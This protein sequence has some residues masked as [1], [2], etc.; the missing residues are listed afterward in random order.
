M[1]SVHDRKSFSYI[2]GVQRFYFTFGDSKNYPFVG[3]WVEVLAKNLSQAIKAFKAV[4]PN[5][6][7]DEVLCCCDYYT[8]KQFIKSGMLDENR[9]K[10]CHAII[11]INDIQ[12]DDPK[13]FKVISFE[14]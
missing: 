5:N 7:D 9:G 12:D 13:D 14:S 11:A 8:E 2:L 3:G 4:Y 1:I 6:N 10:R